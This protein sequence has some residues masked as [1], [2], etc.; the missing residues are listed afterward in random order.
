[1]KQWPADDVNVQVTSPKLD[2][3]EYFT[4]ELDKTQIIDTMVG[5]LQRIIE[6]PKLG[7]QVH[8]DVPQPVLQAYAH[9]KSNGYINHMLNIQNI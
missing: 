3:D 7:Y 4:D 9:L 8:Q 2:Y 6:Y 1:M 5:D